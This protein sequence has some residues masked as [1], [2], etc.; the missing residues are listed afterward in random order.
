MERKEKSKLQREFE[1]LERQL[2]DTELQKKQDL[3][4]A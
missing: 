3:I 1:A 2:N 4:T